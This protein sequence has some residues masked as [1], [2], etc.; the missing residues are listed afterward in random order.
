MKHGPTADDQ[1]PRSVLTPTVSPRQGR[2]DLPNE[3]PTGA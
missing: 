2:S 3:D 1:P